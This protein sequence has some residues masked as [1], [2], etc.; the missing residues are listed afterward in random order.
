MT[1]KEITDQLQRIAS[2]DDFAVRSA[3]LTDAWSLAGLGDETIEPILRFM[4]QHPAIDFGMP[5]PLVHFLEQFYGKGYEEK[6]IESVQRKPTATTVWMLNRVINGTNAPQVKQRL[7]ATMEGARA[8][9]LAD[10]NT[11]QRVHRFLERLAHEPT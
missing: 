10:Q 11:L 9:P 6:L 2:A 7:I 8:N 4:E 5:G 3:E 1:R